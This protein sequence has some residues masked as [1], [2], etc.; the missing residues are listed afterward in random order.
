MAINSGF[1]LSPLTLLFLAQAG[2]AATG[3]APEK[4][5]QDLGTHPA[6]KD[7]MGT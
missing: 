1:M 5:L 3:S 7:G 2:V 4:A 6:E